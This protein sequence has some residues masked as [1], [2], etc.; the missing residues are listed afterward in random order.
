[1]ADT[2]NDKIQSTQSIDEWMTAA[3]RK[4][5]TDNRKKLTPDLFLKT[6]LD[7]PFNVTIL[8]MLDVDLIHFGRVIEAV[9]FTDDSD[10]GEY[11]NTIEEDSPISELF[12]LA[13]EVQTALNSDRMSSY[14]LLIAMTK[15]DT[16]KNFFEK[17]LIDEKRILSVIP[18]TNKD[19]PSFHKK[20]NAV[21]AGEK[22]S[23]YEYIDKF[24]EDLTEKA[25]DGKLDTIVGRDDEIRLVITML[26][27]R[28]KNNP[29]LVGEPG[30][31]KTSILEGIAQRVVDGNVPKNLENKRIV[32]LNMTSLVAGAKMRGEFEERLRKVLEE[33][34][35][36]N[37]EIILFIDEIHSIVSNGAADVLKPILA[38][39]EIK[40]I[41]ATTTEEFRKNLEK[42]AALVR[43]FQK[44]EVEEPSV[45]E[46]VSILRG[47]VGR[48]ENF[49]Q[50]TISDEAL[51]S[52]SV[53]SDRYVSGRCL[54]D[55]AVD[56]V[57]EAAT[58]LRMELNSSPDEIYSAQSIVD[59][60]KIQ[61]SALRKNE[62]VDEEYLNKF[63]EQK[64]EAEETL[65]ALRS[66]WTNEQKTR[67]TVSSLRS[68]RDELVKK[69]EKFVKENEFEEASKIEYELIPEID[70]KIEDALSSVK[71][72]EPLVADC[73]DPN[74]IASVVESWTGVPVGKLLEGESEKLVHMEKTLGETVIGQSEAVSAIST[75][76]RRSRAGVNDP[77]RPTGSFLFL[78]SS[79][80][81][82]TQLAKSLA[83]FMFD[84]ESAMVRIDMSEFSEKHS[85]ARLVGAPPGY[86]GYEAG[87]QLTEAV[88]SRPYSVVLMDEVEKA[89]SEVFDILLQVFDDGR[90]TDGQGNTVDFRNTIIVLTSNLGSQALVDDSLTD[91]EKREFVSNA[92]KDNFRPEFLNRLDEQIIFQALTQEE[93]G[94][95]AGIQIAQFAKRLSDRNIGFKVSPDA[96]SWLTENGYDPAYGARPLRRLIQKEIGD[97]LS[98]LII[99][100]IV[101]KNNIVNVELDKENDGLELI[102]E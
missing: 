84:D 92:V 71:T 55:K 17:F 68:E 26:S 87:G 80:S 28:N 39:G 33:A 47:V 30:V 22:T 4:A 13:K 60:F 57:D 91:E 86:V 56:L 98:M 41:G 102:V 10:Y 64:A 100:G 50:V 54:P 35:E 6:L 40:L 76:V 14:H 90:L 99:Q 24:G 1:M 52:A 48:Y 53:L 78:G 8:S 15:Y 31:G 72:V 59:R 74:S 67:N 81:G 79:G 93:L 46:T 70:S 96:V 49:H 89:H 73:V 82:K 21:K 43:R 101:Q 75:A 2:T 32:A 11:D 94:D 20:V 5:R 88:R 95:I 38:R 65:I 42:D 58:R 51:V 36:S 3:I 12:S 37:G 62:N 83:E 25:A 63:L 34:K 29:I 77:N 69:A 61:E 16:F 27:R 23:D 9:D 97:Q 19:T 44:I 45:E 18:S 7:Q 85:V 66:R